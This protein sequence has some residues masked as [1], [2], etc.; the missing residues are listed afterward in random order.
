MTNSGS[1]RHE[2]SAS[3]S[4]SDESTVTLESTFLPSGEVAYR[5]YPIE[6]ESIPSGGEPAHWPVL[7]IR[8]N[9]R[10]LLDTD[11]LRAVWTGSGPW[12]SERQ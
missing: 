6:R 2:P 1:H 11:D 8:G 9:G 12:E 7:A 3:E 10:L 4:G 5:E